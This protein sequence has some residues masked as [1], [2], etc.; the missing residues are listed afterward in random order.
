MQIGNGL[1]GDAERF[2]TIGRGAEVLDYLEERFRSFG[3]RQF[4]AT[5]L[6]LPGRPI[7][8]LILRLNWGEFRGDR[9]PDGRIEPHDPL[10]QDALRAR[11]PFRFSGASD[12]RS[13][14]EQSPL[15]AMA[16]APNEV[17]LIGVPI[18]AFL[19]YQ[20][21]VLAAGSA[22][23]IDIRTIL[24]IPHFVTAA[25]R[26]LLAL[27]VIRPDRPGDLSTRERK[28]VELSASGMTAGEIAGL[29][30]ISQRTV[31]AH[32]QNASEKMRAANKT[33]T[34]VQALRYGQICV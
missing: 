34:V 18:C 3:A 28:V 16:G 29:L 12:D 10:F 19:P 8:P 24:A 13:R 27:G 31:H 15:L 2:A 30:S 20:A 6:P 32:L 22:L 5:G 7:E 33:Q 11:G 25:F 21:C 14:V 1:V 9:L 26:Q 4:L 23:T 17:D